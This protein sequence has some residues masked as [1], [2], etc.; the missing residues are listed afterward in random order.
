VWGYD[1]DPR[2]NLVEVH[3]N[4]LRRKLEGAGLVGFV[5]TVRGQGYALG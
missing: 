3:I 1:F 2:T 5:R 4:R